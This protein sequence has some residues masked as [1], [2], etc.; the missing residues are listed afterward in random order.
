MYVATSSLQTF[1]LCLCIKHIRIK[2][3]G[4]RAHCYLFYLSPVLIYLPHS[5][6]YSVLFSHL[7]FLTCR[8]QRP[9]GLRLRSTAAR[10]LQSWVRIPPGHG[11][12]SV[13]YIC[14]LSDRGLCDEMNTR[15]KESYRL[16]RVVV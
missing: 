7:T 13:V 16:W 1:L 11:C 4:K 14:A 3:G 9:R 8:S 15:P 10:F 6:V 5:L 12:L 2:P